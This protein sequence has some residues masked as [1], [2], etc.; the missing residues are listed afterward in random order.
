VS[1]PANYWKLGLFVV[2]GCALAMG[3]VAWLGALALHKERVE[4]TTFFDE[5]VQ[6]LDVGSSVKFRGVTIGNVTKIDVAEDR[7][8]VEVTLVMEVR[9]L[10]QLK[11]LRTGRNKVTFPPDMRAQI[12]S[13]GITGMK[14]ILI[15]FFSEKDYPPPTLPFA[16][17]ARYIPSAP[18]TMK[19]LEDSVVKTVNQF[20][21]L[22]GE[23]LTLVGR[24][25]H[26]L[27][28]IDGRKLPER[29]ANTLASL[30]TLLAESLSKVRA[31]DAQGLSKSASQ[32]LATI[33][34]SVQHVDALVQ[35]L[36][37]D[38]GLLTSAQ[39]TTDSALEFTRGARGLERQ[40]DQTLREVRDAAE[41]IHRLA[42]ELEKDPD[43][44]LKG[45]AT[46]K[47]AAP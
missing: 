32:T 31:V 36:E 9:S 26:I 19:N 23:I 17:P 24:M 40:L 14:F 2:V 1:T 25:N 16:T 4:Y 46:S 33:D 37:G 21:D 47:R 13:A 10:D 22:A 39:R 18:S 45:R 5:S 20:P 41:S 12:T 30:D 44:L 35:R 34:T 38:K 11:L 8:H 29:A 43:M 28:E 42:D 6:G 15:D 7:R 3:T 27:E